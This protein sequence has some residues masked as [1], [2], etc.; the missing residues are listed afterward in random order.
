[1]LLKYGI[2]YVI[3]FVE[4]NQKMITADVRFH[5]YLLDKIN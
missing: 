1:M 2:S 3:L 5:K 4:K